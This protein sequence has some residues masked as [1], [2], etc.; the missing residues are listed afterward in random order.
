MVFPDRERTEFRSASGRVI[1]TNI[2]D[3]GWYF[4]S[5]TRSIKDLKRDQIEEF[6]LAMRTSVDN[7]LRGVWRK[8]SGAKL[9]YVGRREAGLAKRNETVRL[10]YPDEF[11]VEFEFGAKDFLPAKSIY[12]RKDSDGKEATEED[13]FAQYISTGGIL[14]PFIIDHYRAAVQMSRINYRSLEF[15][16]PIA[17]EL[18]SKPINLKALK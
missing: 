6:Q 9:A 1:Q 13:R 11:S 18:F 17:D 16:A 12:M 4:D 14:A 2:G 10:I 15:N 3:K 5:A 8:E 7:L